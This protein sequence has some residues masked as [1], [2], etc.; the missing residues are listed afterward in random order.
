MKF[1]NN[2]I[3]LSQGPSEGETYLTSFKRFNKKLVHL[4]LQPKEAD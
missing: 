3:E 1:M 2:V 4:V